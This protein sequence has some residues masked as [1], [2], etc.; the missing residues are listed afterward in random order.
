MH[1]S[2]FKDKTLESVYA[3]KITGC[4]AQKHL[5]VLKG[6][7][8]ISSFAFRLVRIYSTAMMAAA[9]TMHN[10]IIG[11]LAVNA[12]SICIA[13][14]MVNLLATSVFLQI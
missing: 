5:L 2:K 4:K 1:A 10:C 11:S 13:T 6:I 12:L 7:M 3:L 14:G 8:A 9:V